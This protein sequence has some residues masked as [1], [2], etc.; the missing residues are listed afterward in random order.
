MIFTVRRRDADPQS[1]P[2][3]VRADK[4]SQVDSMLIGEYEI[5]RLKDVAGAVELGKMGLEIEDALG[6]GEFPA[7]KAAGE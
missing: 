2:R 7:G 4:R 3:M 6:L 1:L 5:T